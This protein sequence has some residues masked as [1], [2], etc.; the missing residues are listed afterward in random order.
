MACDWNGNV[1]VS[2]FSFFDESHTLPLWIGLIFL[3]L[4]SASQHVFPAFPFAQTPLSPSL[5]SLPHRS[6]ETHLY[7]KTLAHHTFLTV[8]FNLKIHLLYCFLHYT[9]SRIIFTTLFSS[10]R[11]R[12]ICNVKYND[13]SLIYFAPTCA[14]EGRNV[15]Q[16]VSRKS[17]NWNLSQ[18]CGRQPSTDKFEE[19][20]P[21]MLF[22][23][24]R[25]R[26]NAAENWTAN[27]KRS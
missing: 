9:F 10:A 21:I 18:S 16:R 26:S 11:S 7:W 12:L 22:A 17:K 20:K 14:S 27:E 3:P 15:F 4:F 6:F 1:L 5:Q 25:K 2:L 19:F 24:S 23:S 8:T 13:N